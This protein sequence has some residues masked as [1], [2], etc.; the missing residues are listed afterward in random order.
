MNKNTIFTKI[1]II[2]AWIASLISIAITFSPLRMFAIYPA[3]VALWIGLFALIMASRN[4]GPK[5]S[6]I[7]AVIIAAVALGGAYILENTVKDKVAKD[8]KFEQTVDQT[9]KD[10]EESGELDDALDDIE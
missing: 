8:E 3:L 10:A 2:G 7:I 9:A 1:I 6:S 5:Q 4:K